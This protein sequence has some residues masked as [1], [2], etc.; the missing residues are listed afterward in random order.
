MKKTFFLFLICQSSVSI[1]MAQTPFALIGNRTQKALEEGVRNGSKKHAIYS[2]NI[3]NA[4]TPGFRPILSEEDQREL[5]EIFPNS[6]PIQL[7]K[8]MMEHM[9]QKV[10]ENSSRRSGHIALYKKYMENTKMI[11]SMGKK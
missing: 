8:I 4:N 11:I 2:Y 5:Q 1:L 3:A 7:Q 9:A 10:V 6:T